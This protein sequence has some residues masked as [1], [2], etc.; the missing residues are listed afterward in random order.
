MSRYGKAFTKFMNRL[1]VRV[2][3]P[4]RYYHI[5][6]FGYLTGET[7]IQNILSGRISDALKSGSL[8]EDCILNKLM[9]HEEISMKIIIILSFFVW[10]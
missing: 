9:R 1:M 5:P 7:H 3:A 4:F 10:L 8:H 6:L 2:V